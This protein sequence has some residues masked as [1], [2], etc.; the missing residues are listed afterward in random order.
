GASA[1]FRKVNGR[2][3][4]H[5]LG[6]G[7][8]GRIFPVNPKYEEIAGLTCYPSVDVLPET[9]DLAIIALPAAHV[10]DC[11]ASLGRK[12]VA[13][14]VVFSSGFGET[15]EAGKELERRLAATAAV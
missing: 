7:Y 9:P 1:D 10:C 2:P 6:K 3:L 12:G 5:F 13:A 11:V 15:G 8:A 14:A 4:K